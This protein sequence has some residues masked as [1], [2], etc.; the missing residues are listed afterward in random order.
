MVTIAERRDNSVCPKELLLILALRR[1]VVA[2]TSVDQLI[3]NTRS[4]RSKIIKW[5]APE[6]P[7][8]CQLDDMHALG[9]KLANINQARNTLAKAAL[10]AGILA[11]L[12]PHDLR[13]GVAKILAQL[14]T[15][16]NRSLQTATTGQSNIPS[17]SELNHMSIL[18]YI[19]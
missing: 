15:P 14:K 11:H 17:R 6:L 3:K 19:L 5:L 18:K 8:L 12:K 9:N 10:L 7:L 2:A 1:G 4:S 13:L 16:R